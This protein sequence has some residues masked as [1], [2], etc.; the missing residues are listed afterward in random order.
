MTLPQEWHKNTN[1]DENQLFL[2]IFRHK[3]WR[4]RK[5]RALKGHNFYKAQFKC[6]TSRI[7]ISRKAQL[8]GHWVWSPGLC[9]LRKLT[10]WSWTV[11][12]K[13]ELLWPLESISFKFNPYLRSEWKNYDSVIKHYWVILTQRLCGT[14]ALKFNG[15]TLS[16]Y[17]Y[18][19]PITIKDNVY[20]ITPVYNPGPVI[21]WL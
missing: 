19:L 6:A 8:T 17:R 15:W 1:R 9:R 21:N 7:I 3:K 5:T 11:K 18:L 2:I 12:K 10:A 4:N 20:Y 13:L 14:V 16:N